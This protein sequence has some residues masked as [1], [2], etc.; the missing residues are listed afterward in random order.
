MAAEQLAKQDGMVRQA[1]ALWVAGAERRHQAVVREY[2]ADG[3]RVHQVVPEWA[4]QQVLHRAAA[5]AAADY[6]AA[7]AVA[8]VAAAAD[9]ATLM[10]AWRL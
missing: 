7:A 4:A 2:I 1:A 3:A 9:Q 6:M 5:A 10:P 8:G